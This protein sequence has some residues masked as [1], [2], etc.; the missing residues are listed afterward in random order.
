MAGI[1]K[2]L[3]QTAIVTAV[4]AV[5][6]G[7]LFGFGGTIRIFG[8]NVNAW[9][10]VGLTIGLGSIVGNLINDFLLQ[11]FLGPQVRQLGRLAPP[12]IAGAG[13]LLFCL[14][15]IG[16]ALAPGCGPQLFFLAAGTEFVVANLMPILMPQLAL[17]R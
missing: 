4:G 17:R 2:N 11:P 13:S 3:T 1:I 15:F 6:S 10:A 16:N 8:F 14:F 9:L 5:L 7:F 12:L